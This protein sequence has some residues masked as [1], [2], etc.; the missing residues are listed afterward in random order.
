MKRS[1]R[2]LRRNLI[3]LLM[4]VVFITTIIP[5]VNMKAAGNMKPVDM[6]KYQYS[7]V[8]YGNT[9]TISN[10]KKGYTIKWSISKAHKD[11]VSFSKDKLVH[12][13]SIKARA[14]TSKIKVYTLESAKD[15]INS[16]Y[17]VT[18][19]IYDTK[20]KKV[21]TC[22]D[23]VK[24]NM[25]ATDI[26]INNHPENYVM[27]VN[28]SFN[29]NRT[30][31]PNK[32]VNKTFW[33]VTDEKGRVIAD[34]KIKIQSDQVIMKENGI[35]YPKETGTYKIYAVAYRSAKATVQR[36]SSKAVVIKV[37]DPSSQ[38]ITPTITISPTPTVAPPA[39][40]S[41]PSSGGEIIVPAVDT[42]P[43][44]ISLDTSGLKFVN[45]N[46]QVS[47]ASVRLR[48]T[49]TDN[50]ALKSVSAVNKPI[51]S[52]EQVL[53]VVGM[54]DFE[55]TVP[56]NIG[57]NVVRIT[58]VDSS[59]N[60][61]F[62]EVYIDRLSDT[63][64]FAPTVKTSAAEDYQN[65]FD[66]IIKVWTV[67]EDT[68]T[69]EDDFMC[70]LFTEDSPI[71]TGIKNNTLS[72]GDTYII[73]QCNQFLTGF[74]GVICKTE[75]SDD[76]LLYPPE[77]YEVVY[78]STVKLDKLF[79]SDV[80]LD[81]S[82]G[83]DSDDPLAF[84]LLPDGTQYVPSGN[85]QEDNRLL[86]GPVQDDNIMLFSTASQANV[87]S[88]GENE[89]PKPGFQPQE[90][91]KAIIPT[92]SQ[93]SDGNNKIT[94]ILVKLNNPVIYDHDGDDETKNDQ[95]K[96]GGKYGIEDLKY[97]GGIEWHPD[98]S[99]LSYDLL[100]QQ[101]MSKISYTE[102]SEL[103]LEYNASIDHED[104]LK[105]LIK[106]YNNFDNETKALLAR[107]FMGLSIQ[108]VDFEDKIVLVT[109]GIR[110]SR[111]PVI[112]Q[113]KDIANE[114]IAIPF[115]PILLV[116]IIIDL[117]GSLKGTLS[118]TFSKN[119]DVEK[120]FNLQKKN[121]SG[122]YGPLSNNLG[123]RSYSMPFDRQFE[124][125]DKDEAS[126]EIKLEGEAQGNLEV[127]NGLEAGVM[128]AGIVPAVISGVVF[129]RTEA[130]LKG[131]I[132]I[133]SDGVDVDGEVFASH[134]VG[135]RLQGDI[136]L[137]IKGFNW[138]GGLEKKFRW[139]H[140]FF[141]T[142]VSTTKVVGTVSASDE[143]RN[144]SNNPKLADVKVTLKRTD[145]ANATPVTVTTDQNGFFEIA[146]AQEGIYDVTFE[147][148]GYA[149]YTARDIH[150]RG[151]QVTVDA[152]LDTLYESSIIGR[153]TIADTDTNDTNNTPLSEA[154]VILTKITGSAAVVK[155]AITDDNGSYTISEIPAGLYYVDV[156][157][158][159][160]I[161]LR[162]TITIKQ[163]QMNFY[164]ATLE[165]IP[166]DF[167]G[168]GYASG[169]IYDVLTG[170]GVSDLTLTV[171]A[172][173]GNI[174]EGDI[175]S[176]ITTLSDGSYTAGPLP[177]GNYSVLITDNRTLSN[178]NERYLP[179]S[180]SIKVL[181]NRTITA[182][183]G[184]VTTS[185][186][187][188][189]LRIVLRWGEQPYDLDSHLVGPTAGGRS[190]HI[191]YSNPTYYVNDEKMADLDLDDTS[192]YGPETTTIYT[193]TAG[194]YTF[195]VHNYSD[196]SSISG[197]NGLANSGAYVQ[198]YVGANMLPLYTFSVP[199]GEGTLWKVF[200]YD[201]VT[202]V[203]TPI[204]EMYYQRNPELVGQF[205]S[206]YSVSDI[207]LISSDIRNN[208][209]SIDGN[210][211]EEGQQTDHAE[212]VNSVSNDAGLIS[213]AAQTDG[214][215]GT[216]TGA[217]LSGAI[218]WE[219][220]V[221]NTKA[222]IGLADIKVATGASISLYSDSSF[223]TEIT[224]TDTISLP[225][226][227]ATTIYIKVTSQDTTTI[228][229]YAVT[230]TRAGRNDSDLDNETPQTD[231]TPE[232]QTGTDTSTISL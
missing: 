143:D 33:I 127:G 21:A 165:C 213:V 181:G 160:Y 170:H 32:S 144:N 110:L 30:L 6:N 64:V 44:Q 209:K 102:I 108:G 132:S 191:Y 173:I 119:A 167:S 137:L 163:G 203:I 207:D 150:V 125:F 140:M 47:E 107:N 227:K 29:F 88:N 28:T 69:Y 128:M 99:P 123:Q 192:S 16:T 222:E 221:D 121:F 200:E 58:A 152:I 106:E 158:D 18:A 93:S 26:I 187:T 146:K 11:Y 45:G 39:N 176:T 116:N 134:G 155:Y 185:L 4:L 70:V 22:S 50:V 120:G 145:A 73:P 7:Y 178:E 14:T 35:F 9:Y 177:A 169:I 201:S 230:I 175:V 190:F 182:Q 224:G 172:G 94:D 43:P 20:G 82:G 25:D 84:I 142:G 131:G 215:P 226:G 225:E 74:S 219:V 168:E 184:A 68:E 85:E 76:A 161:S 67:G 198:V 75:E 100:P 133:G 40:P 104:L 188:N 1:V 72:I 98:F 5:P 228:K 24:I 130:D 111:K 52:D 17:R 65:I 38:I 19:V 34:T 138:S 97:T 79:D 194:I 135:A 129:Y 36:A 55:L 71:V 89:F 118:L 81:F 164:N 83:I 96:V 214:T 212:T 42:T 112:G 8:G 2:Y 23:K 77:E 37:I 136:R 171:R 86:R 87:Q 211:L 218:L 159:G 48:G 51:S 114:S 62:V 208:P 166:I 183:N 12:T 199:Q 109:F 202:S 153:I 157:K 139:E 91:L 229:Y 124:I 148:E 149:A 105:N 186:N 179:N 197:S 117:D 61:S 195:Y 232:T 189:Q 162:Q 193:P 31:I 53:Q 205:R 103:K 220:N 156:S 95:I 206:F 60:S 122:A 115:D 204:N 101:I 59:N 151:S 15:K 46:I 41:V 141:E 49:A 54:T 13:K 63:I 174:T 92:F 90:L 210:A 196:L 147:K 113:I 180:F 126:Y 154:S 80:R 216:Q 223:E 57:G 10:V 231:G 56:L 217:D 78:F 66:S 3:G 27:S